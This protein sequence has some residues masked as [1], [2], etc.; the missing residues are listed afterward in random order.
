MKIGDDESYLM[1][2]RRDDNDP[3]S[4]FS[5]SAHCGS[6]DSIFTGSN[7]TAHFDQS[8]EA[9]R[10][11]LEFKTLHRN[12]TRINLTEGCF[13]ALTRQSR[14]DIQVNFEI[15]RYHLQA[16]LRGRVLV[17]GEDSTA[18]LQELGKMAY[19]SEA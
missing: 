16:T 7:G 19:H 11:F 18:F 12:E 5:I 15:Q 4:G 9:K 17:A 10:S 1:I 14:G 6:G 13:L 8:D 2:E 3:Y